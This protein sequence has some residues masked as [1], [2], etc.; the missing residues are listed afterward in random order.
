MNQSQIEI[1][2]KARNEATQAFGEFSKS[3]T[4]IASNLLKSADASTQSAKAHD[5]G[6]TAARVSAKDHRDLSDAVRDNAAA[7]EGLRDILG[8]FVSKYLE[9]RTIFE[10]ARDAY[11]DY[12]DFL[13]SSVDAYAE[14]EVAQVRLVAALKAQ[15]DASPGLVAQYDA[16]TKQIMATTTVN[17]EAAKR[18]EALF[19]TIGNVGPDQMERAMKAAADYSAVT[20]KSFEDAALVIA[21]ASEGNVGQLQRFGVQITKSQVDL[22]GMGAVFDAIEKQMGGQAQAI[23]GTLLGSWEQLGNR[24]NE[25][26]EQLGA[27]L[28]PALEVGIKVLGDLI[29]VVEA[30][31]TAFAAFVVG[32]TAVAASL[33]WMATADLLGDKLLRLANLVGGPLLQNVA[34]FAT[35]NAVATGSVLDLTAAEATLETT[36]VGVAGS[37]LGLSGSVTTTATAEAGATT[38]TVAL[39]SAAGA[40]S[41]ALGAITVIPL[42]VIVGE[43]IGKFTGLTEAIQHWAGASGDAALA[44]ET[45]GAKQDTI[46]RAIAEGAPATIAYAQAVEFLQEKHTRAAAGQ[47]LSTETA[48]DFAKQVDQVVESVIKGANSAEVM[49][50]SFKALNDHGLL[51]TGAGVEKLWPQVDKLVHS[52]V[53]LAPVILDWYNAWKTFMDQEAATKKFDSA[54]STMV[55]RLQGDASTSLKV[56]AAAFAELSPRQRASADTFD[57]LAPILE[58]FLDKGVQLPPLLQQWADAHDVLSKAQQRN[59]QAWDDLNALSDMQRDL[60]GQ[61][62]DSLV[63]EVEYYLRLGASVS[64]VA[65]AYS[66]QLSPAQVKAIDDAMKANDRYAKS[67][68]STQD[69]IDKIWDEALLTERERNLKGL[70]LTVA[71]LNTAEQKEKDAAAI[72]IKD[73][74]QLQQ[75]LFAIDRKY[76]A[77]R[78]VAKTK[79]DQ[80]VALK[81]QQ[82]WVEYYDTLGQHQS[83]T[84]AFQIQK[85]QEWQDKT[86]SAAHQAGIEDQGYYDALAALADA[87]MQ[88]VYKSHNLAY[89]AITKLQTDLATGWQKSFVDTVVSTGNFAKGFESIFQT[90]KSDVEG[91]FASMLSSIISGFLQ[92]LLDNVSKAASSVSGMIINALT[93]GGG[94]GGG[95]ISWATGSLAGGPKSGITSGLLGSA[96]GGIFT[97]GSTTAAAGAIPTA[98]GLTAVDTEAGAAAAGGGGVLGALGSAASSVGSALGTTAAF[99]ATNPVGWAIDA[100]I[101]VA[102]LWNH[103]SGPSD[104]ELAGRA[105]VSQWA[106]DVWNQ[107]TPDQKRQAQSAGWSD[108][109]QAGIMVWMD[110]VYASRGR[111][112]PADSASRF[113]QNM[114]DAISKGQSGVISAIQDIDSFD[115]GGVVAGPIGRAQLAVV[116]GG[117]TV[118]T[119]EQEASLSQRGGDIVIHNYTVLDGRV[120]GESVKRITTK[121][122]QS[123]ALRLSARSL[124]SRSV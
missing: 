84:V 10:V 68:Q 99:L 22:D 17:D 67:W 24:W 104:Q 78:A 55:A 119:P 7:H 56:V 48:R 93:G 112:N 35:E 12:T 11:K 28:A 96:V 6:A 110:T 51:D 63:D 117:E 95:A 1:L 76:D 115:V 94:G 33:A 4:D 75:A 121:M 62:N 90:I 109:K 60:V 2:L 36:T 102:A 74:D 111:P 61:I 66:D 45:A 80:D 8:P 92:P 19:I 116:H 20:G 29:S 83:D 103:F 108:P 58:K 120:I 39:T 100:G 124:V 81:T 77:Q 40:L 97:G 9:A 101:G 43:W 64:L 107:L 88:E 50:A 41:L 23:T 122:A 46:N 113:Y 114:I 26:K 71:R 32:S 3:I 53:Q 5:T 65:K 37:L 85:I 86:T 16:L 79:N 42:S 118:R 44:A 105:A 34:L 15:G 13:K 52:G 47:Q 87:K 25:A 18:A 69:D 38:S 123:G 82:L 70:D 98:F 57:A 59:K 54:V 31:P 14:A 91:V 49:Q 30:S 106:D 89:Q 21:K 72:H 27:S 73:E